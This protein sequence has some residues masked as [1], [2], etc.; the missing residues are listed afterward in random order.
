M[1]RGVWD[2]TKSKEER[3][4]EKGTVKA[5]KAIRGK[6]AAKVAGVEAAPRKYT[7]RQ[8]ASNTP[9]SHD[10]LSTLQALHHVITVLSQAHGVMKAGAGAN[11]TEQTIIKVAAKIEQAVDSLFPIEKNE[12]TV[13]ET[14]KVELK[15]ERNNGA[16][17]QSAP[18]SAP[19]APIAAPVQF[20]PPAPQ[21]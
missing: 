7:R 10:N 19:Q 3:E 12:L 14:V 5:P 11:R 8:V 9:V 13:G 17:I 6:K 20:N 4:S 18:I 15:K 2:R 1:P 21:S 16:Q